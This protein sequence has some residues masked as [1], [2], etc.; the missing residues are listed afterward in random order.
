MEKLHKQKIRN[1]KDSK[2]EEGTKVEKKG[3]MFGKKEGKK[4][5]R[6]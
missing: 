4:E 5:G 2:T 1:E 3:K 6:T